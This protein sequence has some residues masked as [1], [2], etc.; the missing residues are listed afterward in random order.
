MPAELKVPAIAMSRVALAV[1]LVL[2]GVASAAA[3]DEEGIQEMVITGTR[4]QSPNATSTSPILAVTSEELKSGGRSDVTDVLNMLPQINSNSLGQDL[5]NRTSGLNSAGGVATAD[6]RGLGPN[7]TLVLVDGRRLGTGSP[8]TVIQSPAPDL[9][10]IP[11]ALIERIEVVTGGASAVYGSDAIAG[12]VNFITKKNFEGIELDLQLGGNWHDNDNKYM[13]AALADAGYDAPKGTTWDGKTINATLTAGANILDGRGNVTGFIG[14]QSMDPVRSTQ[15]DFGSLSAAIRRTWRAR[16]AAVPRTPTGS[17]RPTWPRIPTA[18]VY[19]VRGNQFVPRRRG[20]YD[21]AGHLQHAAVHLHAAPG[22]ALQ[23]GRD[24]QCRGHRIVQAVLRVH[25][26]GRPHAPGGRSHR[27][28]QGFERH[29]RHRQLRHQLQQPAADR[30]QQR[31]CSARPRQIAL[32]AAGRLARSSA[33]VEIGRRNVEGG[34][35]TYDYQHT[36][37]RAVVGGKGS[38]GEGWSYDLY[39]QYYYTN[40]SNL[41]GSDFSFDKIANALQV[42]DRPERPGVHLWRAPA[43]LQHL[44]RRWRHAGSARL[45]QHSRVGHRQ[46]ASSPHCTATSL[47]T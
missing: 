16:L 2:A 24:G 25:L 12:V 40:F 19:S 41:N 38:L 29:R 35:R 28:V 5:G 9:D 26:H 23:R 14:Y 36:N 18:L 32:D 27:P 46:H 44:P 31:C 1:S 37:Y 34:A 11:S 10:Q 42:T 17:S 6:L 3:P 21:A 15:R 47:A 8:Q 7:R 4:I 33:D 45:P 20:R 22:H 13:Q 30:A 43:C 39:G